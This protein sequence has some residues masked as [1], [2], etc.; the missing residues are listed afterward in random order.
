MDQLATKLTRSVS[1]SNMF[2]S[3]GLLDVSRGPSLGTPVGFGVQRVF[4]LAY[5]VQAQQC[6]ESFS[7]G[8]ASLPISL[9]FVI[10]TLRS[11]AI[12]EEYGKRFARGRSSERRKRC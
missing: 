1:S 12:A 9:V 2:T 8:S 11:T 7:I 4:L 6:Q 3:R 10:R 5:L